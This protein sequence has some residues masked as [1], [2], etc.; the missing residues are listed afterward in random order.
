MRRQNALADTKLK[1]A[2]R[3]HLKAVQAED[4]KARKFDLQE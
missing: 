1:A 4:P 2:I 3:A